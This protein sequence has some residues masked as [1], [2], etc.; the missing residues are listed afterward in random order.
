M[1][2]RHPDSPRPDGADD[3]AIGDMTGE[4]EADLGRPDLVQE[5][6]SAEREEISDESSPGQNSDWLPQ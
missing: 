5:L 2:S 3:D 1:T 4:A 6:D